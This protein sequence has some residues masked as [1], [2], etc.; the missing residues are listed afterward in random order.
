MYSISQLTN[1]ANSHVG[2]Y[3]VLIFIAIFMYQVINEAFETKGW[4]KGNTIFTVIFA[5]IGMVAYHVSY[6][7]ENNI[8]MKNQ[9][10][11]AKFVDYVAEQEKHSCGKNSICY[12]S[13]VYGKFETPDGMV[14]LKVDRQHPIAQYVTL[15]KN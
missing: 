10:V 9:P 11:V 6:A 12:T 3:F 2:F 4:G 7:P 1:S 5:L 14:L 8:P 13:L 15:Y